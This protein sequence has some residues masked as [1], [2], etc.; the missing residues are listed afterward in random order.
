V[1]LGAKLEVDGQIERAGTFFSG[2]TKDVTSKKSYDTSSRSS[3]KRV[4]AEV[5]EALD[6]ERWGSGNA[7]G[8][9]R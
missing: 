8:T 1:T 5:G 9:A 6:R 2:A 3:Q 7:A 4:R